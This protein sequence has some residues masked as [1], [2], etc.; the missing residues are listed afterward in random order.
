MNATPVSP[1]RRRRLLRAGDL[2][3]IFLV[4]AVLAAGQAAASAEVINASEAG[5]TSRNIA[6]I[7]ASPKE[8]Y[9]SLVE[10]VALW[11]DP[12]HTYSKNASNLSIDARAGGLFRE[13]LADGGSVVHMTVVYA[14]PGKALRLLG[15]LG[16]LQAAAVNGSMTWTLLPEG[17]GTKVELTYV[18]GGYGEGGLKALAPLVDRVVGEQLARLKAF[19]EKKLTPPV[20]TR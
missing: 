19:V 18:V 12:A 14:E 10:R 1:Q 13:R 8:V 3:L 11:W 9:R 6:V 5:F 4:T 15:G 16:P 17:R 20:P 7:S 2:I